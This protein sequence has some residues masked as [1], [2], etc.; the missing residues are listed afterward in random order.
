MH[1]FFAEK[2]TLNENDSVSHSCIHV[3]GKMTVSLKIITVIE[4][5]QPGIFISTLCMW[6]YLMLSTVLQN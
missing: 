6:Y 4:W 1:L 2:C 3:V 5:L